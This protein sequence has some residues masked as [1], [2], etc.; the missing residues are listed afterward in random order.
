MGP[1]LSGTMPQ[2]VSPADTVINPPTLHLTISA[3]PYAR[4]DMNPVIVTYAPMLP[5]P[6]SKFDVLVIAGKGKS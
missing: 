5:I 3:A 2:Q 4:M 6:D 1:W